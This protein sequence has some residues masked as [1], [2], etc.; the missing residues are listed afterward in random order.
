MNRQNVKRGRLRRVVLNHMYDDDGNH[1]GVTVRAEHEPDMDSMPTGKAGEAMPY[2]P[3]PPDI[4]TPHES[5]DSAEAEAREHHLENMKRFGKGGKKKA[6]APE[7]DESD[8]RG[9]L[10]RKK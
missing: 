1:A 9:A 4:E 10:G 7:M 5:Y 8:M 3:S 2:M 6:A